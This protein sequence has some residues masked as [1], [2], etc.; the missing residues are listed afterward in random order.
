MV[1]EQ[2]PKGDDV[3]LTPTRDDAL[4]RAWDTVTDAEI[5]ESVRWVNNLPKPKHPHE[6]EKPS[7]GR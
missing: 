3:T 7:N 6:E 5:N 1:D 4:G 2:P